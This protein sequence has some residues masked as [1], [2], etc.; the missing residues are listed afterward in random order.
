MNLYAYCGCD[1]VNRID[2]AGRGWFKDWG[3]KILVG[4]IIIAAL[5]VATVLTAGAAGVGAGA[6]FGAMF[7]GGTITAA[8]GCSVAA[9]TACTI[10]AGALGGAIIGGV[11]G[12]AFGGI[13]ISDSGAMGWNI[14]GAADG[15]MWGAIGGAITG[16]FAG[17]NPSSLGISAGKFQAAQFIVNITTSVTMYS[18][19]SLVNDTPM[20]IEGLIASILGGAVAGQ[21]Y[22]VPGV[23][24]LV[25]VAGTE[26]ISILLE[27]AY[28]PGGTPIL[29]FLPLLNGRKYR[30][31][32]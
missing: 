8:A 32:G 29:K 26:I 16:G 31:G 2:P 4:V 22:D 30:Y 21:F 1:P 9:A 3:W 23:P 25:L 24:S 7:A 10:F 5:V 12:F 20:T 11:A 17:V 18:G 27:N 15:F 28:V 13:T 6:V 14:N 19:K